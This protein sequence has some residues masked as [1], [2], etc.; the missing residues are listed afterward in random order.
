MH[1][2][3]LKCE[4]FHGLGLRK[5]IANVLSAMDK[6]QKS[7]GLLYTVGL[8]NIQKASRVVGPLHK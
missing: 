5:E 7:R 3:F 2:W 1:N 6:I 4:M 8:I